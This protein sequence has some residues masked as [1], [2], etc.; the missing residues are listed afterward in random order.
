ML[1]E[2]I[3]V[4]LVFRD[5][6]PQVAEIRRVLVDFIEQQEQVQL[7]GIL[8]VHDCNCW[9]IEPQIVAV[10]GGDG[11]ILRTCRAMGKQQRPMLGIN[12]GRLG[13]LADLTPAEFMQSL[14][15]IASRRYRIVDH[16]MFECR[17]FRDGHEQL[18]SLGL[19]EVSIQAGASLRLI[20]IELL[21]DRVPV[22]T[23]RCDGLIVSTPIGSTAHSLAAG[24]PILKQ[25]LQAFVVTPIS[26]HTLSN[27]PLVDSA[28][29]IFEMRVPEVNEGVTLVIDGQIRE[30][31]QP[32]DVVEIRRADVSCQL[33]R[34]EGWSYYSTLHRKLGW[35]SNP[36]NFDSRSI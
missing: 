31:L 30:P 13:F 6:H 36:V 35:G 18:Q 28:D 14:G 20:D 23:Y 34:L 25:N 29:C 15:E 10:I 17:L 26:P 16:L 32:G 27:R 9:E 21:V 2:P 11:S 7:A 1:P 8:G 22:T 12:L 33:V 24:G 3:Q 5:H 4:G 19:N